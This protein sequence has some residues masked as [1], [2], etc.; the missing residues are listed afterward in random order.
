VALALLLTLGGPAPARAEG[1]GPPWLQAIQSGAAWLGQHQRSDGSWGGAPDLLS[2]AFTARTLQ[3]YSVPDALLTETLRTLPGDDAKSLALRLFGTGDAGLAA[4]LAAARLADGSWGEVS[5]TAIALLGLQE[6]GTGDLAA[7]AAAL[8]ARQNPD[9]GWGT[10]ASYPKETAWATLALARRGGQPDAVS[11]GARWLVRQQGRKGDWVY[12]TD[13]AVAAMALQAAGGQ[14]AALTR[15]YAWLGSAAASGG[16]WGLSAGQPADVYATALALLALQGAPASAARDGGLAWLRSQA[17][18]MGGGSGALAYL[19]TATAIRALTSAGGPMAARD[20]ALAWLRAQ[21]LPNAEY[22]ARQIEALAGAGQ[23]REELISTLMSYRNADGGFA[24]QQ[25]YQSSVPDTVLALRALQTAGFAD[26]NVL[27]AA[28][29]F[30]LER[31]N[32]DGGWNLQRGMASSVWMTAEVILAFRQDA[33]AGSEAA[34]AGAR[35]WLESHQQPD[36]GWGDNGST[37]SETAEAYGALSRLPHDPAVADRGLSYLLSQQRADGSWDD[38]ALATALAILALQ[39]AA[40]NVVVTASDI[41]LSNWTPVNGN[42]VQVTGLV[43]N[44]G[45]TPAENVA[46]AFWRG[47]PAA[48][49]TLIGQQTLAALGAG[50]AQSVSADWDTRG[51]TGL[52]RIYVVADASGTVYE[53]SEADNRAYLDVYVQ[54]ASPLVIGSP[55]PAPGSVT[56]DVTPQIAAAFYS[57]SGTDTATVRVWVDE[58]EVTASAHSTVTGFTYMPAAA[59]ADGSHRVAV[60]AADNAGQT[61]R[62][63]WS[64]IIN[65]NSGGYVRI[66]TSTIDVAANYDGTFTEGAADGRRLLY[67]HPS[68]WSSYLAL[69]VGSLTYSNGPLANYNLNRYI[70]RLTSPDDTDGDGQADSAVTEWTLPGGVVVTQ[71]LTPIPYAVRYKVDVS[72]QGTG[73]PDVR[74]RY[75]FDTQ[76][77]YNDGAPFYLPGEDLRLTTEREYIAPTFRVW[78]DYDRFDNPTLVGEGWFHPDAVPDK[79]QFA[80]WQTS[81]YNG[82]YNYPVVSGRGVTGD[83]AVVMYWEF[84]TLQPGQSDRLIT[85]YGLNQAN[86]IRSPD[87]QV[88]SDS[89][90]LDH[91]AQVGVATSVTATVQNVGE[92]DAANI[93]VAVFDGP[94]D[95]GGRQIGDPIVIPLLAPGESAPIGVAWTPTAAG[96]HTLFV[97]ADPANAIQELDE[98]NNEGNRTVEVAANAL[99][100]LEVT[101][102]DLTAAP[103][104]PVEGDTVTLSLFVHNQGGSP[105]SRAMVRFYDGDPAAGGV[106]IGQDQAI[107]NLVPLGRQQVQVEWPTVGLTGNHRLTAVVDPDGAVAEVSEENNQ[108]SLDL[109][110]TPVGLTAT[111]ATDKTEYSADAPVQIHV[112]LTDTAGQERALTYEVVVE[113]AQGVAVTSLGTQPVTVGAGAT[114]AADHTWNTGSTAAGDYRAHLRVRSGDRTVADVT[115]PFRIVATATLDATLLLNQV[116]FQV[117]DTVSMDS[118]VLNTSPNYDF[119][120]LT[121]AVSIRP[122]GGETVFTKEHAIPALLQGADIRF[123]DAWATAQAQ[124]GSYEAVLTVRSGDQV[125]AE[126]VKPFTIEGAP[127]ITGQLTVPASLFRYQD[128]PAGVTLR[129]DGTAPFSGEV[130]VLVADPA[131]PEAAEPLARQVVTVT[132]DPGA[133]WQQTV[134]LPRL[135]VAAGSYLVILRSLQG[136]Q[137]TTLDSEPLTVAELLAMQ[138]QVTGAHRALVYAKTTAE[139]DFYTRLLN[140]MSIPNLVVT[141]HTQFITELRSDR[142]DLFVIGDISHHLKEDY[143]QELIERV[144]GGAGLIASV[145]GVGDDLKVSGI[146]GFE[147]RGNVSGSVTVPSNFGTLTPSGQMVKAQTTFGQALYTLTNGKDSYPAV[148]AN[149]WGKGQIVYFA[150]NPALA[151]GPADQMTKAMV[152]RVLPPLQAPTRPGQTANVAVTVTSLG[153][154]LDLRVT[155]TLPEGWQWADGSPGQTQTQ[156]VSVAAGESQTVTFAVRLPNTATPG[157]LMTKVEYLSGGEW[158]TY[159]E[160]PVTVAVSGGLDALRPRISEAFGTLRLKLSGADLDRLNQIESDVNQILAEQPAAPDLLETEIHR[161][162]GDF[163]WLDQLPQ[164]TETG[165]LRLA[166]G[167]LLALLE[168]TWFYGRAGQ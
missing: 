62:Y 49:G 121:A 37:V 8:A 20:S 48:G 43:H 97:V 44:W 105:V 74:V 152:E 2:A 25:G 13:T 136:G 167:R 53:S 6:A 126:V 142:Y 83:S 64:F 60:E 70:S 56:N 130:E 103:A 17:A 129:N 80:Y 91:D 12:T 72:N 161:L 77:N 160:E 55:R 99:P 104:Q 3:Q 106:P 7:S 27:S 158:F 113:D 156:S 131:H 149:P 54:E 164:I 88:A 18:G 162:A 52:Q 87:L 58:Q 148:V 100:D 96:A 33:L 78:K 32:S 123:T 73:A 137:A 84:G 16:G 79:I 57:S 23:P 153:L 141:D 22:V 154:P 11:R 10:P 150:F 59:L 30:L 63:E 4:S 45:G 120:N 118:R 112:S 125:L 85:Y 9:G 127:R 138:Q 86:E 166:L 95:L 41:A 66:R 122:Q 139:V 61:S 117:G 115:A 31:Q 28:Y 46:V 69:Q 35:A 111:L 98:T 110:L 165:Q 145:G 108:A 34:V 40:P 114:V 109:A 92:A 15:A 19:A 101:A 39:E 135:N 93:T 116:A 24:L 157:T 38:S 51:L 26:Q 151:T 134:T 107:T 14:D 155:E 90:T 1:S 68:P 50:T 168:S 140:G 133:Q 76:L 36:G 94:R 65:R 147:W 144:Y 5:T 82:A 29:R 124:P 71:T 119:A 81:Y 132:V 21:P 159:L 163:D 143:D 102:A 47:D 75:L 42:T 146:F 67:G 128:L 89:I